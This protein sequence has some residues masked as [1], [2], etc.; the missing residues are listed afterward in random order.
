MEMWCGPSPFFIIRRGRFCDMCAEDEPLQPLHSILQ[1][2][3]ASVCKILNFLDVV[4]DGG[5]FD[6]TPFVS[7]GVYEFGKECSEFLGAYVKTV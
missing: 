2:F 7:R 4:R 5:S 6:E 3:C 1:F